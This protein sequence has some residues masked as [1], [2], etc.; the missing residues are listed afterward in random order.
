M[1]TNLYF[2]ISD[3]NVL[4]KNI[5]VLEGGEDVPCKFKDDTD[6]V[7]PTLIFTP[8]PAVNKCDYI[9]VG[10]PFNRYYFVTNRTL[11]QGRVYIDCHVDVLMSFK[12]DIDRMQVIAERTSNNFDLYQI[13][14][15]IPIENY[16][17]ITTI[18]FPSGFGDDQWILAVTG[19]T[20][21]SGGES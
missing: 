18:N 6:M 15:Q 13:D 9:K 11:S 12:D 10:E 14:T 21:T 19:K 2:N 8:T 16:H 4:N 17:D 5:K 7:N 1:T 3:N 20:N